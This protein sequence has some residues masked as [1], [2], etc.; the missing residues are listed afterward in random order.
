MDSRGLMNGYLEKG[1]GHEPSQSRLP[2]RKE[3]G[4]S[5]HYVECLILLT[6]GCGIGFGFGLAFLVL[7]Y[8]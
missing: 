8:G 4:G 6:L 1:I 7:L 3:R 5:L 2:M